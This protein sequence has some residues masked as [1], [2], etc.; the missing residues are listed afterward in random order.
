M[1]P[2]D[3]AKVINQCAE[4]QYI[5]MSRI[6]GSFEIVFT[7]IAISQSILKVEFEEC[8]SINNKFM[9]LLIKPNSCPQLK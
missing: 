6:E 8:E 4:L 3:I 7:S 9:D 2:K 5:Y 1:S